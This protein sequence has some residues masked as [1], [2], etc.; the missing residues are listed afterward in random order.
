MFGPIK[1][2]HLSTE[3]SL[4]L[5]YIDEAYAGN[6][7]HGDDAKFVDFFFHQG[8][9]TSF[10]KTGLQSFSKFFLELL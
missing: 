5:G 2:F 6:N 7:N 1:M 8:F 9:F 10:Q 3:F 4:L